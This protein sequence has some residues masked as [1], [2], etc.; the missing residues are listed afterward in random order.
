LNVVLV[1]QP[2]IRL[3][4]QHEHNY[5]PKNRGTPV[6][7]DLVYPCGGPGPHRHDFKEMFM[8]LEGEIELTFRGQKSIIRAG[9]TVNIPANA[10]HFFGNASDRP[11]RM[12]CMCTPAGQEEFF[13]NLGV[14]VANR[15][16]E[17]PKMDEAAQAAFIGKRKHSPHNTERSFL[18]LRR[19]EP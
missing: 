2:N 17:P 13:M 16:A 5:R 18:N 19:A 12:L 6:T 10:P 14:T 9:E 3:V 15:T 8:I 4:D 11:T 1:Y 7:V